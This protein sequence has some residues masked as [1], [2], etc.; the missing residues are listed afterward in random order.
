MARPARVRMR[1]RKPCVL[2][3]RRLFGWKV[4]LLTW[5][6]V[7]C[8]ARPTSGTPARRP[9]GAGGGRCD[10]NRQAHG[11]AEVLR[12]EPRG[13]GHAKEV[14]DTL[15]QRYGSAGTRVKPE[16]AARRGT[17]ETT[18]PRTAHGDCKATRRYSA[19]SVDD[20]IVFVACTAV[21]FRLS[22]SSPPSAQAVDKRVDNRASF[23][24]A[25]LSQHRRAPRTPD[26]GSGS[27]GCAGAPS[28]EPRSADG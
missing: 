21:G 2:A 24:G 7:G 23:R 26:G 19:E 15:G 10:R 4:R 16:A 28:F 14:A 9:G 6:S 8:G 20:P 1:R 22:R 25:P 3:R 18:D 27:G 13:H 11:T 5:I 17:A 12:T